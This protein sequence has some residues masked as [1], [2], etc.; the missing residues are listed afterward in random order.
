MIHCRSSVKCKGKEIHSGYRK[1]FKNISFEK[2]LR[3]AA[4]E[5][6]LPYATYTFSVEGRRS[7]SIL[8]YRQRYIVTHRGVGTTEYC[9]K[10]LR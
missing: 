8:K 4:S 9:H 10:L 2:H 6:T 3:T 7:L 5:S 1:I